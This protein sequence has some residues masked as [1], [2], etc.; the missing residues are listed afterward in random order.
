MNKYIISI[1]TCLALLFT[2][3]RQDVIDIQTTSESL[4]IRAQ[5][6]NP[7]GGTRSM[8]TGTSEEQTKFKDGDVVA[9]SYYDVKDKAHKK[10]AH[11]RKDGSEWV[12]TD[13]GIKWIQGADLLIVD[14]YYPAEHSNELDGSNQAS[15]VEENTRF[16]V[17]SDQRSTNADNDISWADGKGNPPCHFI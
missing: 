17:P 16:V 11:Y 2:S 14:A 8:P 12:P 9:V 7:F 6:E 4:R 15:W 3:C 13:G 5:I 10:L 1:V